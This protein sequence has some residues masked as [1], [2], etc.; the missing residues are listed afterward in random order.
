MNTATQVPSH[1]VLQEEELPSSR[2]ILNET[3]LSQYEEM[4]EGVTENRL[5]PKLFGIF[6]KNIPEHMQRLSIALNKQDGAEV[7]YLIH[8]MLGMSHNVGALRL[9]DILMILEQADIGTKLRLDPEDLMVLA[10]EYKAAEAALIQ[11]IRNQ[12]H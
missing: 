6:Q 7:N 10:E 12:I 4:D 2:P 5:L 3:L 9:A 1:Q 11:Y 8:K